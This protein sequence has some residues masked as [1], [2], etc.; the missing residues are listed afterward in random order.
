M[1]SSQ[2]AGRALAALLAPPTR[3]AEFF[4]LWAFATR[5]AAILGP[6]TYGLVTWATAGNHRIAIV[7]TALYFVLG[8]LLLR[9]V[10]VQRGA[11]EALRLGARP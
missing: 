6:V 2:S 7:S 3:M 10:D 11:R 1:G 9:P 4:G 8:L 5:L